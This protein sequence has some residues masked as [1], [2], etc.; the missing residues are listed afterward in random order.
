MAEFRLLFFR[1]YSTSAPVPIHPSFFPSFSSTFARTFAQTIFFS[2][3]TPAHSL[4]SESFL[5]DTLINAYEKCVSNVV[6][7]GFNSKIFFFIELCYRIEF[8]PRLKHIHAFHTC[9]QADCP[10]VINKII[11]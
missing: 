6:S 5:I 7:Q 2:S 3:L 4:T 1:F 11:L 9:T 8:S 10:P